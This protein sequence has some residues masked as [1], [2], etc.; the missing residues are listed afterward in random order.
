LV[1][2]LFNVQFGHMEK[3]LL[4]SFFTIHSGQPY[5]RLHVVSD[6]S[7]YLTFY[8][9]NFFPQKNR[10][11]LK[12]SQTKKII[13]VKSFLFSMLIINIFRIRWYKNFSKFDNH[14]KSEKKMFLNIQ[15]IYLPIWLFLPFFH[16]FYN[17]KLLNNML[18]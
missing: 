18:H 12:F 8:L 13:L 2:K 10:L 9:R 7:S 15:N 4:V 3:S 14:T 1:D 6:I 17:L 5:Y 11:L 16:P